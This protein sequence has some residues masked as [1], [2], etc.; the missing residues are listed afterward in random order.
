MK[1]AYEGVFLATFSAVVWLTASAQDECN[2]MLR[3]YSDNHTLCLPNN[4][5]CHLQV[6][7]IEDEMKQY[8]LK[9]HNHYRNLMALGHEQDMPPASDMMEM[10]W[11]DDLAELAQA[12]ANQCVFDHDC[13]DCR[14]LPQFSSV[15]QNLCL[16]RTNSYDPSPNWESCIKRWYDEVPLFANTSISPFQFNFPAGHFTQMVWATTW[17]IGCGYARYPS[18]QPPYVYDLL[19]T[20]D[21]GPGGNLQD[22]TMYRE[23]EAC[24]QC[25]EGTCCGSDCEVQGVD[26]RFKGLCKSTTP[27]GPKQ[28]IARKRLLWV[29]TF[30]N[31]TAESCET[32]QHPPEAFA[33]IPQFSAGHLETV[34]QPGERA[35]VTF[36]AVAKTNESSVCIT[37]EFDKGPNVASEESNNVLKMLLTSPTFNLFHIDT[38]M[39]AGI[40][41]FQSFHFTLRAAIPVQVGFSFSV[42]ENATA[43]F[44]DIYKV[45]VTSGYCGQA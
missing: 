33:V 36:S 29:C 22:G 13:G 14:R 2:D 43:Q 39:G 42:P 37:V 10:E 40:D 23:G 15:G 8:I 24:S 27:D 38:E 34:V 1:R 45:Q 28:E 7:G 9:L 31:D 19:Y 18:P 30:E 32:R 17:R 26:T 35:G 21:Y 5:Q 4:T 11:D 16:D 20:C 25:P 44:L 41:G 6:T 3:R 12:H